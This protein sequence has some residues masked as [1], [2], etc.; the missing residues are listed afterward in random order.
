MKSPPEKPPPAKNKSA[1][2]GIC[3]DKVR[4]GADLFFAHP[5]KISLA[6]KILKCAVK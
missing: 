4:R 5:G 1:P 3:R 6:A 2:G